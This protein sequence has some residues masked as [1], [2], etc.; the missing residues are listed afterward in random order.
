MSTMFAGREKGINNMGVDR[1]NDIVNA[2]D[3]GDPTTASRTVLTH[4]ETAVIILVS[5]MQSA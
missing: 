2:I 1:N 5:R 3:A 4:M